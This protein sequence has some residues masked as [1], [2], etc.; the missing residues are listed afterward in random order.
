MS[1]RSYTQYL[2]LL[3]L[4][5]CFLYLPAIDYTFF[6]DDHFYLALKNR[7]I[8]E[9]PAS[10]LWRLLVERANP[11]EFLP[12]RDFSYWLDVVVFGYEAE[13]FHASNLIWYALACGCAW[14]ASNA[15]FQLLDEDEGK[16]RVPVLATTTMFV[17]ALHPAHIEPV[18][19]I[20]GRKDLLAGAL[21]LLSLAFLAKAIR[22][23]WNPALLFFSALFWL[24]SCFSKPAAIGMLPVLCV[25]GF[26]RQPFAGSKSLAQEWRRRI[27]YASLV[28]VS[29]LA[30]IL[31][32]QIGKSIGIQIENDPG[33]AAVLQRA[34][35]IFASLLEI[36]LLPTQPTLLHDVYALGEWH[37]IVSVF[38]LA[39]LVFTVI[40]AVFRG[41]TLVDMAVILILA[42][43]LPYLQFSPFTTWS[44]ASDRFV[45]LPVFGLAMLLAI[46][47]A[48][49]SRPWISSAAMTV[50]LVVCGSVIFS[51]VGQWADAHVLRS[52][53]AERAPEYYGAV[54][55]YVQNSLLPRG[56]EDEAKLR[57]GRVSHPDARRFLLANSQLASQYRKIQSTLGQ[58][59]VPELNA[60]C[61]EIDIQ[62]SVL[63][64]ALVVSKT[65]P[66]VV[67]G[68]ALIALR[69]D[70]TRWQKVLA[71]PCNA[72]GGKP[73]NQTDLQL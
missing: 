55:E 60:F 19:W 10:E 47:V 13:G 26:T 2:H 56:K 39:I 36:L 42:P 4:G 45:F 57:I 50:L 23:C 58:S 44:M 62:G 49:Q 63:D 72:L 28:A 68:N 35:R 52:V 67:Y 5:I 24:L 8:Y 27:Y 12:V 11:W 3:T 65:N 53:E 7:L 17:F 22:Y 66:D 46:A 69:K 43:V 54:R 29:I 20:S 16:N 14:L 1:W 6:S 37:W 64:V 61:A 18:V 40:Q 51:R 33:L 38:A 32:A 15:L 31:H 70:I 41:P 25:L 73:T 30:L 34:S 21:V 48:K 59:P 71:Q 9:L